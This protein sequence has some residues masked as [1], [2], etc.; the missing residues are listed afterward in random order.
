MA[1]RE[2][3]VPE[4]VPGDFYV[5][6]SCIDC[7]TCRRLAPAVF[8][9]SPLSEQSYVHRQPADGEETRAAARSAPPSSP[10]GEPVLACRAPRS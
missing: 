8:A 5:D 1:R 9:R 2:D 6:R 7:D 4:S 3:R 10:A